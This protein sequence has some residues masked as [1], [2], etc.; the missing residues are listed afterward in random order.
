MAVLAECCCSTYFYP[1][2]P[3]GG[4]P[5]FPVRNANREII[6]IHALREEGDRAGLPESAGRKDFYPRP[7]RGGRRQAVLRRMRP[8]DISIHALREEGDARKSWRRTTRSYFYPRP[9]RGGQPSAYGYLGCRLQISIHALREEGDSPWR[10]SSCTEWISIHAL[11][12]EGDKI[13]SQTID[14]R[15]DFYPRPPRGGRRAGISK[16]PMLQTISI[17]ALR[18][19]GDADGCSAECAVLVF[20]STPSA[21]RATEALANYRQMNEEDFYPRPPR[22]GRQLTTAS[23][24]KARLFLSTPSARRATKAAGQIAK[25]MQFLST[26]SARRATGWRFRWFEVML[27]FYPRPPRGGR[28]VGRQ[29]RPA[30]SDFYPRPPRGG[31][32]ACKGGKPMKNQFLSTPSARR[33][34]ERLDEGVGDV[35]ISIHALREEGDTTSRNSKTA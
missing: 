17:H 7:P 12:E 15:L 35:V 18:E 11:R 14:V 24:Q 22:G 5:E 26:P 19:E 29:R 25:L 23:W 3:R 10:G 9:P 27:Y 30:H 4:R 1:R 33:A 28:P 34:T 21:R 6:S 13:P 32:L 2:P 31:R 16:P 8:P 20:L